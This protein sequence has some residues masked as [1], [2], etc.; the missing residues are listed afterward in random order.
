MVERHNFKTAKDLLDALYAVACETAGQYRVLFRG[1]SDVGDRLIPKALRLDTLLWLGNEWCASSEL[2]A[3]A[4]VEG[5]ILMLA[6]F[7]R[8]VDASGLN[9]PARI[10]GP[11]PRYFK[12]LIGQYIEQDSWRDWPEQELLPLLG[13]A[14][15]YGVPTRLLDWSEHPFKAAYFCLSKDVLSGKAVGSGRMAVWALRG[16]QL[17]TFPILSR[18]AGETPVTIVTVPHADNPNLHAQQG[19]FTLHRTQVSKDGAPSRASL[20]DILAGFPRSQLRLS[21]F[22]LPHAEARNLH[23]ILTNLGVCAAH[24][25]PG[26]AGCARMLHEKEW[27]DRKAAP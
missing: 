7:C 23:T 27:I 11:V 13:L 1:V 6:E 26:Y 15:H 22:T 25:Y 20:D 8:W 21:Q 12:E 17:Y 24:L 14:Q 5:E 19:V 9:V 4:Q 3:R 18:I 16:L 10:A 2:N